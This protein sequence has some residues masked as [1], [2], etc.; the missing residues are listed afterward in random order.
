[1]SLTSARR[2]LPGKYSAS[3]IPS[4]DS[5]GVIG[6][7]AAA[8]SVLWVCD[9]GGERAEPYRR[10][11][12]HTTGRPVPTAHEPPAERLAP[13]QAGTTRPHRAPGAHAHTHTHRY[14]RRD[15]SARARNFFNYTRDD[16]RRR[17][18]RRE[19]R[20]FRFLFFFYKTPT[21]RVCPVALPALRF[22]SSF[23]FIFFNKPYIRNTLFE[24]RARVFVC[25][26]RSESRA[27]ARKTS[28]VFS[29]SFG[30]RADGRSTRSSAPPRVFSP[31]SRFDRRTMCPGKSYYCNDRR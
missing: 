6:A 28:F 19:I 18:H 26:R 24:F 22:Y 16:D 8:V 21:P 29:F 9:G 2:R 1:M 15:V 25:R 3:G 10:G 4:R 20:N 31:N 13:P 27:R 12:G 5:G 14:G 30:F 17:P 23:I 7:A 11:G